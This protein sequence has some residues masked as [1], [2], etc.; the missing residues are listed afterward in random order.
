MKKMSFWLMMLM[1]GL[2]TALW[3]GCS[4]D[5]NG[6][7]NEQGGGEQGGSTVADTTYMVKT[8]TTDQRTYTLGYADK[9]VNTID[10]KAGVN[11]VAKATVDYQDAAKKVVI[12]YTEQGMSFKATYTLNDKG[13]MESVVLEDCSDPD[14]VYDYANYEITN[15]GEGMLETVM[16]D[17]DAYYMATFASGAKNW[18]TIASA[19]LGAILDCTP[20]TEKNNYSVDLNELLYCMEVDRVI[21]FAILCNL[22]APTENILKSLSGNISDESD[23]EGD[24]EEDQVV[25]SVK[26]T[27][28]VVVDVVT[29]PTEGQINKIELKVAGEVSKT[30]NLGY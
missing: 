29:T 2:S 30:I 3:T 11:Q 28:K 21:D 1:L 19:D 25:F 6:E 7:G 24:D 26:A 23:D 17:D 27:T 22:I 10:I 14:D 12:D 5:D 18:K 15:N 4:D 9:R 20:G 16:V 8:I 13:Y